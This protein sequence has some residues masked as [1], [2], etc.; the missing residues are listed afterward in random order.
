MTMTL[1]LDANQKLALTKLQAELLLRKVPRREIDAIIAEFSGMRSTVKAFDP[2]DAK[3]SDILTN[4]PSPPSFIVDR[5]IPRSHGVENAIGGAGKSTR[6]QWEAA[7]IILGRDLY[8]QKVLQPGPVL[9]ITKED[10][11]ELYEWRLAG[12][13]ASM[14]DL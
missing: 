14:P 3:V 5:S 7:H 11:R 1:D 12:V 6:H 8:G 10:D 9:T 4:P 2:E 13:L